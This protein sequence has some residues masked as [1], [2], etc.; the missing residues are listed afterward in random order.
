MTGTERGLFLKLFNRSGYVLDFSTPDFDIFTMEKVGIALCAH[1]KLSKGR[2]LN[3]YIQ[4]N[5]NNLADKLLFDLLDYYENSY[6]AFK[7]ETQENEK[8]TYSFFTTQDY[9]ELYVKCKKIAE[10]YGDSFAKDSISPIREAFSSD[11][12]NKQLDIMLANQTSNPTEAIGKAKELIESC[13]KAILEVNHQ[14]YDPKS[15]ITA[16]SVQTR[17]FLKIMPEDIN[18][19]LKGHDA[20]KKL[21]GSL[22]QIVHGMA[23]LRNDYGSGHGK[24][25]EYKGLEERHAKLAVGASITLVNFLWDS[26]LRMSTNKSDYQNV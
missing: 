16:L 8:S 18:V 21:L 5:P 13:C 12:I 20:M 3:E 10:R 19:S 26:H 15:D 25:P 22:G 17:K 14:E 4:K 11:Y 24:S 23:E 6:S 1:Y 7:Q 2:S 9:S